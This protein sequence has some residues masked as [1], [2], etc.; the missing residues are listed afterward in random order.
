MNNIKDITPLV[1][2]KELVDLNLAHIP[3]LYDFS[4]LLNND[5]PLLER[6]CMQNSGGTSKYYSKIKAKY[7]KV[8]IVHTGYGSTHSGWRTHPRYY[9]MIR[10]FN[11]RDYISEL[12]TKYDK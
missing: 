2:C 1:S 3:Q 7:P 9:E 4:P 12:F 10:M 6:L 5:F 8:T 11:K